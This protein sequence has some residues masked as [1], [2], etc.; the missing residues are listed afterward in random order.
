MDINA[1]I[2]N[3]ENIKNLKFNIDNIVSNIKD[4][5]KKLI[6]YYHDFIKEYRTTIFIFGIDSLYFQNKLIENQLESLLKLYNLILNRIYCEY[7][8]LYKLIINYINEN[9]NNNEIMNN[10]NQRNK[11]SKYNDLDIYK[12][13]DFVLIINLQ[14]EINNIFSLMNNVLIEKKQLLSNHKKKN[15][16][17]LNIDNFVRTNKII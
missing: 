14:E 15:N 6:E 12:K 13:Y 2:K 3:F 7:Y 9:L 5:S 17:G 1:N 16:I 8:K 4:I 11:F 10:I